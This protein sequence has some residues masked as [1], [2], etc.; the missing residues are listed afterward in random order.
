MKSAD[1]NNDKKKETFI[2]TQSGKFYLVNS[3]GYVIYIRGDIEADSDFGPPEIQF[4]KASGSEKFVAV[5]YLYPPSSTYMHVYRLVNGTLVNK[6]SIRGDLYIELRPNG[7]ILNHWKK[8]NWD[9][10]W[11]EKVA[12][13]KWSSSKQKY[14]ASGQLASSSAAK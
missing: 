12:I 9:S 6:L 3:K 5:S 14:V 8:Y 2:I 4:V 7:E 13:Y 1:L 10:G 11:T